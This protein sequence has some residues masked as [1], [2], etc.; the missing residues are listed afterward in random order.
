LVL[1]GMNNRGE[2]VGVDTRG[3]GGVASAM[4]RCMEYRRKINPP[5]VADLAEQIVEMGVSPT[6]LVNALKTQWE[7]LA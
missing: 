3:V 5:S 4:I 6:E 7:K 1:Q 2:S